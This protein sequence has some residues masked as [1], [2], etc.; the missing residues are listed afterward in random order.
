SFAT[1]GAPLIVGRDFS[2]QD[3]EGTAKVL[4]VNETLAK[5]FFNSVDAAIGRH[6][7]FGGRSARLDYEIVGVVKDLKSID[8]KHEIPPWTYRPALQNGNLQTFYLRTNGA[9]RLSIES[10]RSIVRAQDASAL[11]YNVKTLQERV[12]DTHFT[13]VV[14][15]RLSI[16]FA[17]IATALAAVGLY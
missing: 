10:L 4:V 3:N 8:L 17:T 2:M 13:E 11:L 9:Q 16:I 14:L 15:S 5:R 1:I 7:G 12:E 6:I